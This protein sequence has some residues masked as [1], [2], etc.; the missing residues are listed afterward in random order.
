MLDRA[1]DLL[2][3]YRMSGGDWRGRDVLEIGTGWCPWV[4]LVLRLAGCGRLT[5]LDINPWLSARTAAATTRLLSDRADRASE[6]LGLSADAIRQRLAPA[7]RAGSLA[8]WLAVVDVEYLPRVDI[9]SAA[10]PDEAFDLVVSS[11]LLEHLPPSALSDVHH[12]SARLLRPHGCV[13]HRFNPQDHYSFGDPSISG[14]NFLQYSEKEW[15]WLGGSGL[16]YHNRLRCPQHLQAIARTGLTIV[17]SRTR[18][19]DRAR[20]AI[21]TGRLR[22]HSTFAHMSARELSDDYMWVVA[23]KACAQFRFDGQSP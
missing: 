12:H 6:V 18:P 19:D 11:N 17:H 3:L 4:P 21:E 23:Q 7:T 5:T 22:V 10:L 14:A 8:E 20:E 1:L 15:H 13:V 2:S 9:V 16:Q